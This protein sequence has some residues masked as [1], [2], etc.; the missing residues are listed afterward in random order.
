MDAVV[1]AVDELKAPDDAHRDQG[2]PNRSKQFDAGRGTDHIGFAFVGV[3]PAGAPEAPVSMHPPYRRH[4]ADGGKVGGRE[5]SAGGAR[6]RPVPP[7]CPRDRVLRSSSNVASAP[8]L[9]SSPCSTVG[10]SSAIHG[11]G[12]RLGADAGHGVRQRLHP[13]PDLPFACRGTAHG[14]RCCPTP[15]AGVEQIAPAGDRPSRS[16]SQGRLLL[17]GQSKVMKRTGSTR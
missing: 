5:R 9:G 15:R 2:P 16:R 8:G 10:A 12:R 4:D 7:A 3:E 1:A 17:R 14:N 6:A 13:A 11:G